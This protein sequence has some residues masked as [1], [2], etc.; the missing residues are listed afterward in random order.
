M[1]SKKKSSGNSSANLIKAIA[2]LILCSALGFAVMYYVL[3]K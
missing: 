3:V 2:I 1:S